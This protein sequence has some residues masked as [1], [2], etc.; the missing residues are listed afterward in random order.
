LRGQPNDLH[1]KSA[2][3]LAPSVNAPILGNY[4]GKDMGI[5]PADVAAMREALAKSG[6]TKSRIDVFENA[7]HGFFADY[8]PSYDE[9]DAKVA[10]PHALAWFAENGVK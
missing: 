8:R 5:P 10:W 4:G 3:E 7:Q 2:I 1:P 9:A 6:N